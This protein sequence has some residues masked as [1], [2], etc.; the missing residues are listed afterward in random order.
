MTSEE[1]ALGI[2]LDWFLANFQEGDLAEVVVE[3][4]KDY[5]FQVTIENMSE[6]RSGIQPD[7]KH[8]LVLVCGADGEPCGYFWWRFRKPA[9]GDSEIAAAEQA[10]ESR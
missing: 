2:Q 9:C 3:G 8:P 4:R 1:A 7:G 10:P 5:V 6:A